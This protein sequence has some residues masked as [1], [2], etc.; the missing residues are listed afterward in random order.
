MWRGRRRPRIGTAAALAAYLD[1][2]AALIS[3]KSVIGYCHAKTRLPMNELMRETLFAD[4]YDRARWEAFAA[5]LADLAAVIEGRLRPAAGSRAP[6]LADAL[7]RLAAGV[8]AAQPAPAHRPEGWAGPADGLRQRLRALQLAPPHSIAEIARTSGRRVFETL[9]IHS[10]LRRFD[11]DPVVANV[12]FMMVGLARRLDADLD[13]PALVAD[14][15]AGAPAGPS[16]PIPG[17][18]PEAGARPSPGSGEA[19]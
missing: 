16:D 9:P 19:P 15:L 14:L 4:A 17:A 3:Q 7:A 5:I 1:Q 8:L 11:E 6:A 10:S 12:Q 2:N 18:A 13:P